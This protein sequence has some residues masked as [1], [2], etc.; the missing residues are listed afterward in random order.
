MREKC[1]WGSGDSEYDNSF[2]ICPEGKQRNGTV[3]GERCG[4]KGKFSYVCFIKAGNS[5][6]FYLIF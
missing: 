4:K 3:A 1:G 6:I 2:K 5:K